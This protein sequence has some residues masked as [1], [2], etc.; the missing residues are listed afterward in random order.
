MFESI[1]LPRDYSAKKIT[2]SKQ[3]H[4][5]SLESELLVLKTLTRERLITC[6]ISPFILNLWHVVSQPLMML[7]RCQL[8]LHFLHPLY[9]S[10]SCNRPNH[11]YIVMDVILCLEW[12]NSTLKDMWDSN[13]FYDPIIPPCFNHSMHACIE[14]LVFWQCFQRLNHYIVI[15]TNN[16]F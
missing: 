8:I 9:F 11:L 10:Y 14:Y 12:H 4:R 2:F 6:I 1:Q 16:N 15:Y 13:F 3:W 7:T 5:S